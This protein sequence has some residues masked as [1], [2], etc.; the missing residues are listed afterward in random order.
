[1]S[2]FR[3]RLRF[4]D[5]MSAKFWQIFLMLCNQYFYKNGIFTEILLFLLH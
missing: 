5:T 3:L 4:V 1:M 2:A